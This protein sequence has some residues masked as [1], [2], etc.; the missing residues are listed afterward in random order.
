[1][2]AD[3]PNGVEKSA[4]DTGAIDGT[5]WSEAPVVENGLTVHVLFKDPDNTGFRDAA[6]GEARRARLYD[7][8]RYMADT[9]NASGELNF[10][11]G[12]SESDGTGPLAQGGPMFTAEDGFSNGTVFQRLSSGTIPFAGYAEMALTFDLGYAWYTGTGTPPSSALDM[13][14]V[15]I[16]EITHCLGFISLMAPDGSSRFSSIGKNTYTVFDSLLAKNTALKRLIGGTPTK[17]AFEGTS[18]D[19]TGNAIVFAGAAAMAVFGSAPSVYS[20]NPFAQG[21]SMEHWTEN[22][23]PGGAVMEPR[24]A[25][26][27]Q[28]RVY[29]DVEVA[30]LRDIGWAKA[31]SPASVPCEVQS[32]TFIQ[33]S[34]TTIA[35]DASNTALVHFRASVAL[36]TSAA[37]CSAPSSGVLRVEYFVNGVSRGASMDEGSHFPLDLTLGTGTYAVRASATRTD[38]S[39]AP[40]EAKMTLSIGAAGTLP[41]IISVAPADSAKDFGAVN[42]GGSA[43]AVYTVKNIG[44]GTLTGVASLAGD[45]QFEFVGASTYSL[46]AGAESVVTARFS[47]DKKGS[48]TATLSFSGNGGDVQVALSGAG[49]KT[50]GLFNCAG[51]EESQGGPA[52]DLFV[53]LASVTALLTARPRAARR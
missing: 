13:Q 22:C 39:E 16:H 36:D 19:L 32:V 50:G 53:L 35:A 38:S 26:G 24:Y 40:V 5:E 47:P 10:M 1:M 14:S 6:L 27:A 21:T 17:P 25:Y 44:G 49:G 3:G 45:T 51:A 12:L 42:T 33:P 46:S 2:L 15:A 7:A 9:L 48:F 20:A 34:G 28:Q 37:G 31:Q 18:A 52:A 4:G 43:D 11:V 8:L 30:A 41:P 23:I 29:A